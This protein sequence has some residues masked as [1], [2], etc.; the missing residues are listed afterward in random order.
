MK[1]K[2]LVIAIQTA[3]LAVGIGS[4]SIVL[5]ED[6]PPPNSGI[7]DGEMGSLPPQPDG[8]EAPLPKEP[9]LMPGETAG[10]EPPSEG[11]ELPTPDGETTMPPPDGGTT[12]LPPD[13][14]QPLLNLDEETVV[15][16][17]NETTELP[18]G[19]GG[20]Q[21]PPPNG[22]G[23]QLPPPSG[24]QQPL[25][26]A[27][28][29]ELLP[30]PPGGFNPEAPEFNPAEFEAGHI[31]QLDP[32]VMGFL[33]KDHIAQFAPG[34][35]AGMNR[36]HV[37][38]MAPEAMGGMSREHIANMA[39]EAMGGV[40]KNH[41]V[42]MAPEAMGGMNRDH[43]ANMLPE[44]MGGLT[45]NHIVNV[46]PESF[47]GLLP[48]H[49]NSTPLDSFAGLSKAHLANTPP[50]SMAGL[51]SERIANTPPEAV[52]GLNREHIANMPPEAMVGLTASHL[53]NTP[54]EA[55]SGLNKDH[56]A[57]M[58]PEAMGGAS[59]DHIAN[60]PPEAMGGLNR[61]HI[62]NMPPQ[63]SAG[64]TAAHLTNTPPEAM[65]GLSKNHIANTPPEAMAGLT[66]ERIGNILPESMAG[67]T[68]DHIA[69]I[70]PGL[71]SGLTPA[72][73]D[74]VPLEALAGVT[75]E[76][77]AQAPAPFFSGLT[78]E[79]I[80]HLDRDKM[81]AEATDYDKARVFANLNPENL[82]IETLMPMLPKNATMEEDGTMKMPP[83]LLIALPFKDRADSL[84][85]RLKMPDISDLN[86]GF[87]L[88]GMAPKS[89]LQELEEGLAEAQLSEFALSQD[90]NGILNVEGSGGYAGTH[91]SFIPDNRGM[92]QVA[93]EEAPGLSM[94]EEGNYVV[95]SKDR[96]EIPVL[97]A[98]KNPEGVL[99]ALPDGSEVE[100][101]ENGNVIINAGDETLSAIF[102]PV[103]QSGS[104]KSQ[105]FHRM[106]KTQGVLVYGD[107][108][109]QS[110]YATFLTAE[111]FL[112][113]A[114]LF[115]G[116]T[117][118]TPNRMNGTV[119]VKFDDASYRLRPW[120][121]VEQVEEAGPK[122]EFTEDS[123][124]SEGVE[125]VFTDE[126]GDAQIFSAIPE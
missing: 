21:P 111:S 6:M 60:I 42:N 107:G 97:P 118:V 119:K 72:H 19:E 86:K 126:N 76:H 106:N 59:K 40:N 115:P 31:G 88:G 100:M 24:E 125:L 47:D 105:G 20:E 3:I 44:A 67:L 95:I 94:N 99:N 25:P 50:V 109:A 56:I 9:L 1:K 36:D 63:A 58:P 81:M 14:E 38:N 13:D 49:V 34:A 90:E 112:E 73:L 110:V 5:A 84:P 11:I 87:G 96:R 80:Q 32:S 51:D 83:G 66:V 57:N 45:A 33:N 29:A 91:L 10:G 62:T 4:T 92:M 101:G 68:A 15:Y 82:D 55:M 26:D 46:P 114:R 22:E 43:I 53:T 103:V 27:S 61:D 89:A 52:A 41:V 37:A 123:P 8:S 108:T 102:D 39:P 30:P 71:S 77:I 18:I 79:H 54:H 12:M 23:E 28:T 122:I 35:M 74:N 116:V 69:N 65:A 104:D 7:V 17:H 78:M 85:A 113:T 120:F 98:P 124:D 70:P 16:S 121:K 93:E 48:A 2:Q 64:L 75:P 117:T